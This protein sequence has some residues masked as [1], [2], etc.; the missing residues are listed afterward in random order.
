M[1]RP[2]RSGPDP[3]PTRPARA[4]CARDPSRRS[5]AVRAMFAGPDAAPPCASRQPER[6]GTVMPGGAARSAPA[7][8][9]GGRRTTA[10]RP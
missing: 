3:R 4:L 10:A 5:R 2:A 9:A 1:I 8:P 6:L 7:R